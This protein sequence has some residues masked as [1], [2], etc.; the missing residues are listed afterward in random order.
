[1]YDKT[2]KFAM[3][4]DIQLK[5]PQ[6][7]FDGAILRISPRSFE[8]NGALVK[9]EL[10]PDTKSLQERHGSPRLILKK[11]SKFWGRAPICTNK[12]FQWRCAGY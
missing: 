4:H 11:I 10:E 2:R 8:G 5:L 1:M 9:I 6:T 12:Y 3:T 7:M